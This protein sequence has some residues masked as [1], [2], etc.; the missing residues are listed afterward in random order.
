MDLCMGRRRWLPYQ[1]RVGIGNEYMKIEMLQI[2][3]NKKGIT[4]VELMIVMALSL[5]LMAAVYATYNIQ[6][7]TSDVQNEVASV[8]QDLRAVLD[9]MARDIRQ[10][11][12]NPTVAPDINNPSIANSCGILAAQSGPTSLVINMDANGDGSTA[13]ER[14]S[15]ILN[16][17]TLR[18]NGEDLAYNVSSFGF[19]YYDASNSVMVPALSGNTLLSDAQGIDVRDIQVFM[20]IQSNKKDPDTNQFLRREMTKR[21]KMRNMGLLP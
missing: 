10:A 2:I 9:I 15:Y 3:R 8:Q 18:R 11:G 13:G 14:V 19:T 12:C 16:G 17:T 6:K 20:R 21:I 4:L 7:K 1:I 5:L